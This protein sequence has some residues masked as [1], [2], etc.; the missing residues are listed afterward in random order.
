M[1]EP[2]LRFYLD[3][4]IKQDG[5]QLIFCDVNIGH[6]VLNAKGKKRYIP[7]KV[8]LNAS[9]KAEHF[10]I[11]KVVGKR[12]VFS[13]D[14]IVFEKSTKTRRVLRLKFKEL[15][16]AVDAVYYEFYADKM[17]PTYNEFK[18]AINIKLGREE[19]PRMAIVDYFAHNL[20]IEQNKLD[21]KLKNALKP[22]TI[23]N[24]KNVMGLLINYEIATNTKLLFNELDTDKYWN[25][26]DITNQ[27]TKGEIRVESNRRL[28]LNEHGI[29]KSTIVKYA[30]ILFTVLIHAE[31]DGFKSKLDL[32]NKGDLIFASTE[33]IKINCEFSVSELTQIISFDPKKDKHLLE[34]KQYIII[35]CV[36]GLR[37]SDIETLHQ[38]QPEQYAIK[39]DETGKQ[40]LGV[41]LDLTK[42]NKAVAIPL[43]KPVRD[44]LEQNGGLFPKFNDVM[45]NR[46]IKKLCKILQF[47][48]DI[49][50]TYR[51]YIG[52][53]FTE[54]QPKYNVISTHDCRK[55]LITLM[56]LEN[57][58]ES[59]IKNIT[60]P[61]QSKNTREPYKAYFQAGLTGHASKFLKAIEDIDSDIYTYN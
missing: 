22:N 3:S 61:S 51:P 2:K 18:T 28:Y 4:V 52:E 8:C 56:E 21:K 6:Y 38:N 50:L 44:V 5:T 45:V 23:R 49:V 40:F 46:Y 36:T 20:E 31:K 47:N 27:I 12:K 25:I 26:W 59:I 41:L 15:I 55:T 17:N 7:I 30:E 9:I 19:A 60:H 54:I 42:T 16:D 1:K 24:R 43:L 33:P 39:G 29:Q 10:G 32:G 37:I 14:A 58:H 35:A 57:V 48:D 53:S 13:Y 34:A 11:T